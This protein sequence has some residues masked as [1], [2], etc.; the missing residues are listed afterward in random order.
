MTLTPQDVANKEF[1]TVRLREGYDIQQVDQ[2]LDD[3][4]AELRRLN[5][6]NIQL[7]QAL[8]PEGADTGPNEVEDPTP[9]TNE[10]PTPETNDVPDTQIKQVTLDPS[11]APAAALTILTH[12]QTAADN[13]VNEARARADALVADATAKAD[14][15]VGEAAER[16]EQLNTETDRRRTEFMD[17]LER[18]ETD[19]RTRL[20]DLRAHEREYRSRLIAYHSEQARRLQEG[21]ADDIDVESPFATSSV[22][23]ESAE[24]SDGPAPVD[25]TGA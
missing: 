1:L 9:E 12:A 15:L 14:S 2:F 13:L 4:E 18:E 20:D 8:P 16:S 19:L 3:V 24:R 23:H 25:E 10:D 17:A 22:A 21:Q 11:E 6:E 5:D 7:R